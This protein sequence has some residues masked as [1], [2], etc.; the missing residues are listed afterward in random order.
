MTTTVTTLSSKGDQSKLNDSDDAK[1]RQAKRFII[2]IFRRSRM[3][4]SDTISQ[5]KLNGK[6][7]QS[8]QKNRTDDASF[9]MNPK[10][11][12]CIFR[13]TMDSSSDEEDEDSARIRICRSSSS[14]ESAMKTSYIPENLFNGKNKTA[15]NLA[16]AI[17]LPISRR[18]HST[19][20]TT[21]ANFPNG[22]PRHIQHNNDE[23]KLANDYYNNNNKDDDINKNN[24]VA[25][26]YEQNYLFQMLFLTKLNPLLFLMKLRRRNS[27]PSPRAPPSCHG[28]NENNR[29]VKKQQR[30]NSDKRQHL[31]NSRKKLNE[32]Q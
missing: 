20:R 22:S 18:D 6:N 1:A 21:A 13:L 27:G 17:P 23:L 32:K 2:N 29:N 19:K 16:H 30:Q 14:M 15:A 11:T 25:N 12:S 7:V 31:F 8:Q 9:Y 26:Y 5:L 28:W 4:S 3:K 10:K 24:S